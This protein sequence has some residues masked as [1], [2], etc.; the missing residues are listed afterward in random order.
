M[1]EE[2]RCQA[3]EGHRLCVNN[4]GF[5]GSPATMNLCSKCYRDFRL[6]EQQQASSAKSSI[7][8]SP[9][10]SSTAVESV[11]QVPLLTL[12]EV[13]GV[14]PVVSA[15]AIS[16]VT[17][18]KPQQQQQQ[19]QQQ[20]TRCTVCRKRVGLTG[21]KCKCGITFCGSHRY[22]ENHGCTFD[23]KKI[24]REEIARANPVVKAEK[25]VRI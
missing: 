17:E 12:P 21:F 18:Q 16:Q 24:G 25:I 9:S 15:V 23:F 2:H 3:P 7:S 8:T 5:L 4:C 10:S 11:S 19:Q 13:K 6:K 1:A 22:P 14:P 20:P